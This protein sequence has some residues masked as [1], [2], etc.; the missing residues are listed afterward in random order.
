[1]P[2]K[3]FLVRL[4]SDAIQY[5]R[6]ATVEIHGDH[7]AFLTANGKLAAL[8]KF[9]IVESWTEIDPEPH[10]PFEQTGSGES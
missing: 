8:F 6:A 5:V 4:R 9:S 7:L 3:T 10:P 1:M 2:N